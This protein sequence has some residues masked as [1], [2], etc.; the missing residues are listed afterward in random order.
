MRLARAVLGLTAVLL[1]ALAGP[2]AA[3]TF[4]FGAQGEPIRSTPP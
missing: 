3:Q 2:A 1:L 4:V